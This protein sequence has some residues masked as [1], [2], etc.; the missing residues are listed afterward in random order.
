MN[1]IQ[2]S[3]PHKDFFDLEE[4]GIVHNLV[5]YEERLGSLKTGINPAFTCDPIPVS[6]PNEIAVASV[7]CDDQSKNGK[8]DD[9]YESNFE[10]V[11]DAKDF[12]VPEL[13]RPV[14]ESKR[15]EENQPKGITEPTL[16]QNLI[17]L[18]RK[19]FQTVMGIVILCY[20]CKSSLI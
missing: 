19:W 6:G 20:A 11:C 4:A 10:T 3:E 17:Y 8:L 18:I 7:E 14:L 5:H 12:R 2:Y 15:Q 16:S 13:A 9:D 1:S